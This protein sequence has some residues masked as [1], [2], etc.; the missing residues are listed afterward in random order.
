MPNVAAPCVV[1]RLGRK[2]VSQRHQRR[3]YTNDVDCKATRTDQ[4]NNPVALVEKGSKCGNKLLE[5]CR[6]DYDGQ[7]HGKER[8]DGKSRDDGHLHLKIVKEP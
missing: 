6:E 1:G 5:N 2:G 8:A 7:Q 4:Q 3:E